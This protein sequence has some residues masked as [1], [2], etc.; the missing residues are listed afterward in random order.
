MS[1]PPSS[2]AS[3]LFTVRS[4]NVDRYKRN[5]LKQAV[6]ELRFPTLIELGGASPPA[7][8]VRALRKDYPHFEV[9]SE[10]TISPNGGASGGT[11]IHVMRSA[12]LTWSVSL[13]QSSLSIESAAY[14]EY[15][16]MRKRVLSVLASATKTIDTD[17]LT[18]IGLRY[19]N[20]IDTG[21]D[22]ADGWINPSL[23]EP[24]RQKI[25]KN[26]QEFAGKISIATPDGGCLLQHGIRLKPALRGELQAPEYYIDV[27][28]SRAE[29]ALDNVG[30]M[31]DEMHAE[32]FDIF[33]WSIGPKAREFLA[34]DKPEI[35]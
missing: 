16:D 4:D 8:L 32:A 30:A 9:A 27:D 18:R 25:F 3:R 31:L 5:F 11:H 28:A 20:A 2:T 34:A 6:C 26:V 10:M 21:T 35:K 24:L 22:P 1:S 15:A 29:V 23:V 12:K 14:T 13:R 7:D 17:F 33:D 19:I